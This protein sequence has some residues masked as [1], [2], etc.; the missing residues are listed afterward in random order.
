MKLNK[1]F[2]TYILGFFPT[3]HPDETSVLFIKISINCHF[4][5]VFY[6]YCSAS[7]LPLNIILL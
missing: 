6:L 2:S 3:I 4:N 7:F 1:N 5:G